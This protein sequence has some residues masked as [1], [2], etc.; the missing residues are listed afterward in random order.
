ML[1][2]HIL[3]RLKHRAKI[4]VLHGPVIRSLQILHQLDAMGPAEHVS[5]ADDHPVDDAIGDLLAELPELSVV[6]ASENIGCSLGH[7][8][9]NALHPCVSSRRNAVGQQP[10]VMPNGNARSEGLVE[11]LPIGHADHHGDLVAAVF[12]HHLVRELVACEL[13][14]QVSEELLELAEER[15]ECSDPE[16]RLIDS[17]SLSHHRERLVDFHVHRS[18]VVEE[19][20]GLSFRNLVSQELRLVVELRRVGDKISLALLVHQDSKASVRDFVR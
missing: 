16:G 10:A 4:L 7:C 19:A 15:L 17:E 14:D 3:D 8:G 11:P 1:V 20:F 9:V 18:V 13:R 2:H 5:L 6:K 12:A